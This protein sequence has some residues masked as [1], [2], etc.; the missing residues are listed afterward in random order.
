MHTQKVY[1]IAEAGVN[2]NGSLDRA[3]QMVKVAANAGAD[4]IKFQTFK[5]DTLVTK[6]AAKADYQIKASGGDETQ[7]EMLKRLELSFEDHLELLETCK[8]NHIEFLSSPFDL[9]TIEFL[10]EI[11]ITKWKIPSGEITNLPY[12]RRIASLGQE[13]I[14]STGMADLEEIRVA[15]LLFTTGG[16]SLEKITILHCN[17]AYPTPMQDVNLKAIQTIKESFPGAKIGY[18]D[19]TK[20]IE[21]PIAAV[22]MGATIIEK[23]FTLDKKL[24]GP[25]HKASLAPDE[26]IR[27][28][29]AV[30]NIE[31][32]LG[33][34]QKKPSPSEKKNKP[35]ARKS[36]VAACSIRK[37]EIF[38]ND[39]LTVKRPG[40]GISPMRWDDVIGKKASRDYNRDDQIEM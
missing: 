37:G 30:R 26:L 20:G 1:I 12:L 17:T 34:G 35:I 13:I 9:T 24:P 32:A 11:G 16:L 28:V 19:H 8:L 23:H 39:N 25:D 18:S 29:K 38:S 40:N 15:I 31:I 14:L 7:F 36:I 22:A 6:N 2:H 4:A 3:E 5:A 27:M 33:N 21:I 10:K